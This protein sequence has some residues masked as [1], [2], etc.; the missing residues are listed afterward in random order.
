MSGYHPPFLTA[1]AEKQGKAEKP[2]KQAKADAGGTL[3]PAPPLVKPWWEN[4]NI[5]TPVSNYTIPTY[6]LSN[7]GVSNSYSA[8]SVLSSTSP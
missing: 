5:I 7:A 8:S 4:A 2:E 6:T 3:F 1:P